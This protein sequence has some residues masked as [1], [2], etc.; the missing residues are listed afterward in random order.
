MVVEA[1]AFLMRIPSDQIQGSPSFHSVIH[2]RADGK[3]EATNTSMPSVPKVIAD[4]ESEAIRG[5]SAATEKWIG[6]GCSSSG[7]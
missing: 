6:E 2:R 3:F 1:L 7:K 5:I 4:S